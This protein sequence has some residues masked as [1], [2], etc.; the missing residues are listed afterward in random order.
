M[1]PLA[2][3]S[4]PPCHLFLL[5]SLGF[6]ACSKGEGPSGGLDGGTDAGPPSLT[7]CE[8]N[9]ECQGGEVCREGECREACTTNDDCDHTF[10]QACSTSLGYCVRCTSN[11]DCANDEICEDNLCEAGCAGDGD[12]RGGQAC[13]ER[14]CVSLDP[15]VCEA[16]TV[17]CQGRTIVRCSADGTQAEET[18][19]TQSQVCS[20]QESSAECKDK[21]CEPSEI[22]CDDGTTA[23]V[24]S[25]DGTRKLTVPC[26]GGQFCEAGVCKN[27]VCAPSS[28]SCLGN[29]RVLCSADGSSF[30]TVSCSEDC[31][32]VH[33]CSCASGECVE[34]ICSPGA[35]QC[36]ATGVRTCNG[37]GTGWSDPEA[38][39]DICVGGLCVASTCDPG[40][41]QCS[42]TQLLTCNQLGTGYEVTDCGTGGQVCLTDAG[43]SACVARVCTPDAVRCSADG[44]AVLAC[45]PSG[46]TESREPCEDGQQCDRGFCVDIPCVPDCSGR[47]CGPDPVCGTSCGGC[48]GTCDGAGQCQVS[49]DSGLEVRLSWTPNTV[50]LDLYLVKESGN[51]CDATTCYHG[52]CTNDATRPDWDG[53][54]A[55]SDGDPALTFGPGGISGAGPEVIRLLQPQ[56]VVYIAG[57]HYASSGASSAMATVTFKRDGQTLGSVSRTLNAGELWKGM[58]VNLADASPSPSAGTVEGTFQGCSGMSCAEDTECPSG[59]YCSFALPSIAFGTCALGCRSDA[60]CANGVCNGSHSCVTSV[61]P[62]GGACTATADCAAGLYCSVFAQTCQ[63]Y[64][65]T[66]GPC[67]GDPTCCPISEALFCRQGALFASCS[68]T[69]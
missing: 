69:P 51:A 23:F 24:C 4:Y 6:G 46:T 45:D 64:C 5:L 32:S 3:F 67:L 39:P 54:G 14:R 10:Y 37:A 17:R 57:A 53:S 65:T 68:N 63:E 30:E 58:A 11:S 22:G 52:T 27:Q 41:T 66:V 44:S 18:S 60:E 35:G 20:V 31:A 56:A 55:L 62:W 16:G 42:G 47:S 50:D 34:R 7:A 61:S 12:C 36:V 40:T 13:R 9:L 48:A 49:Q 29:Q 43:A 2:R 8:G 15:I 21:L 25:E 38:C 59:M 28:E 33:G 26:R 1:S 19:C